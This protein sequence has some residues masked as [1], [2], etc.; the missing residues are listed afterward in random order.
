MPRRA[1]NASA[2]PAI[3]AVAAQARPEHRSKSSRIAFRGPAGSD[4]VQRSVSY[5]TRV[6]L[7]TLPKAG[8]VG[9][10]NR[11]NPSVRS[12]WPVTDR[13]KQRDLVWRPNSGD[14]HGV[15]FSGPVATRPC[16]A[17]FPLPSER[18]SGSPQPAPP[19]SIWFRL[20]LRARGT[21]ADQADLELRRRM[22]PLIPSI[23]TALE[24]DNVNAQRASLAIAADVPAA[25]AKDAKLPGAIATFLQARKAEPGVDRIG[26]GDYGRMQPTGQDLTKVVAPPSL[27]PRLSSSGERPLNPLHPRCE[28]LLRTRKRF[29]IP[30]TSSMSQDRRCQYSTTF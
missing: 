9:H 29:R 19:S 7:G 10:P 17:S 22:Q 11:T 23:R 24:G 16:R 28:T 3:G 12:R 5:V 2:R 8:G 30:R 20:L 18:P 21:R 15:P 1:V 14:T 4:R 25:L 27:D 13:S 6:A 26:L